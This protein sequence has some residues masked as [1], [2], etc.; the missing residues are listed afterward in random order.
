[1][2]AG[3]YVNADRTKIVP[4]GS[5]EAAYWIHETVAAR[6]GLLRKEMTKPADKAVKR[7]ATK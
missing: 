1:M 5:P 7:P 3:V 2:T 4:E 6:L